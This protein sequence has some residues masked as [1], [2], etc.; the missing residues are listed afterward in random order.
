MIAGP[1]LSHAEDGQDVHQPEEGVKYTCGMHPMIISDE[2]GTCPIC[3]MDLT[4]MKEGTGGSAAAAVSGDRKIKY[5][6]APMDP[7]YIRDEPGKSPMGMDLIPVYED[8]ATGGAMI[9]IDPTTIQNMG[10]RTAGVTRGDLSR[11]IRTVGLVSYEEPKQYVVN[12]KIAGWV[13]KLYVAET[14]QQVNQ[15]QKLLEIYSPE[16]VTA[17]QELLLARDN[18][19]SLKD[20]SFPQISESAKRLLEASRKRLQLWDVSKKQIERLEKTGEVRKNVTLY[21]PYD[22]IVTMKMVSEGMYVKPGVTLLNLADLS[23]VWVLADIYEYQ[24]PWVKVG[25]QAEVVLPYVNDRRFSAHVSYLYPYVEGKTRTVKA[26]LELDNTDFELRPDMYVTVYLKGEQVDDALIIP[27]EAVLYSGEK[28]TVFVALSGG[29]F[30]PR[31]IKTGL[32]GENGHIEVSQ[33]LFE[34]EQVVTSAQF[35]LDSESKLR[36]AIQKMLNPSRAESPQKAS[37]DGGD[38]LD[39]L[40]GDEQQTEKKELE[41]LFN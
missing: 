2:P 32:Q 27:Q 31:L 38:N 5:W 11:T 20:S 18:Y 19:D 34:G 1:E 41:D 25:Q 36:E 23:K 37:S 9:T 26:R 10:V 33:G 15:G 3:G 30:E 8:E 24:L 14:G 7:T 4:P 21:A 28:E 12:A 35:M 40:F 29:R 22:G 16:L 13:E 6:Q 17:Q 39:N